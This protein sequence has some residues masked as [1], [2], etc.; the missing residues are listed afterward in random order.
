M[1]SSVSKSN[2]LTL[3]LGFAT[4]FFVS[5][6][7]F[8]VFSTSQF[9]YLA[10]IFF[11]RIQL[12]E[13]HKVLT[14]YLMCLVHWLFST[15][16]L[17]LV[18]LRVSLQSVCWLPGT[19]DTFSLHSEFW[20]STLKWIF[21]HFMDLRKVNTAPS[22]MAICGRRLSILP[23]YG[24]EAGTMSVG[25]GC[26]LAQ[27]HVNVCDPRHIPWQHDSGHVA[28]FFTASFS[29]KLYTSQTTVQH[30]HFQ[31]LIEMIC[32][33]NVIWSD[34][35][36]NIWKRIMLAI[37]CDQHNLWQPLRDL[38]LEVGVKKLSCF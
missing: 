30:G 6:G 22:C 18:I 10:W 33:L 1:K 34:Q 2:Y 9:P 21:I 38:L 31:G 5:L 37:C 12:D 23:G 4:Y 11:V 24:A 36:T 16:E 32:F 20:A 17:L 26:Q 8:S 29:A 7:K 19:L 3:K 13:P 28:P 35:S 25:T 27:V 15:Y 14:Q